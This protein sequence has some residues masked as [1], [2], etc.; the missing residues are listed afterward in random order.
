MDQQFHLPEFKVQTWV[1]GV[2]YVC[3]V[4]LCIVHLGVAGNPAVVA[5]VLYCVAL[6]MDHITTFTTAIVPFCTNLIIS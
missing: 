1:S 5:V 2:V 6:F 4:S 3:V